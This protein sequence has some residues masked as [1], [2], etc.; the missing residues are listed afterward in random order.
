MLQIEKTKRAT[1]GT[2]RYRTSGRCF[3]GGY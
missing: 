2:V 3:G 1:T